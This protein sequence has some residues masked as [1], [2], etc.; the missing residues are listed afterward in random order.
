MNTTTM[1]DEDEQGA[2]QKTETQISPPLPMSRQSF[3]LLVFCAGLGMI[4]AAIQI[5]RTRVH[6]QNIPAEW[7]RLDKPSLTWVTLLVIWGILWATAPFF[8]RKHV[9]KYVVAA[10]ASVLL[11]IATG[12]LTLLS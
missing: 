4:I 5:F 10:F 3:Y 12:I 11:L 6:G 8:G 1:T 2:I 7:Y 9:M